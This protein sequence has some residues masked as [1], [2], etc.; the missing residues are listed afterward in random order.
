MPGNETI[1]ILHAVKPVFCRPC[2]HTTLWLM[3][4]VAYSYKPDCIYLASSYTDNVGSFD[5]H[6]MIGGTLKVA[7]S[8]QVTIYVAD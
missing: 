8:L 1:L 3:V 6:T 7:S 5:H 2:A 4:A